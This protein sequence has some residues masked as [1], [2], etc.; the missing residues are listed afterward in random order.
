MNDKVVP[1][2]LGVC[3]LADAVVGAPLKT[4][5]FKV[6]KS[7]CRRDCGGENVLKRRKIRGESV[8]SLPRLKNIGNVA[9]IVALLRRRIHIA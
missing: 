7:G 9:D 5:T 1:N 8:D 3:Q 4:I 6:N 2:T